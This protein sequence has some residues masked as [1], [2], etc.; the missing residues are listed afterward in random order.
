MSILKYVAISPFA[1]VLRHYDIKVMLSASVLSR[2]FLIALYSAAGGPGLTAVD[3][4]NAT[5]LP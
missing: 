4:A 3:F 2:I 5:V 1:F